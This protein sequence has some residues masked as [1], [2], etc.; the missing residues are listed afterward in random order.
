MEKPWTVSGKRELLTPPAIKIL[1][2]PI[3]HECAYACVYCQRF[4]GKREKLI[5]LTA[6]C[7]GIKCSQGPD[8]EAKKY[9]STRLLVLI[10]FLV[11][12]KEN[13]VKSGRRALALTLISFAVPREIPQFMG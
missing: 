6:L 2:H 3:V 13:D 8:S 7:Q 10:Q 4:K 12:R 1:A 5:K 9:T 11:E